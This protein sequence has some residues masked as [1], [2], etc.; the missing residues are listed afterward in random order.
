MKNLLFL[1]PSLAFASCQPEGEKP[2]AAQPEPTAEAPAEPAIDVSKT[3]SLIG[4]PLA[5]VEA[6]CDAAEVMHRV[7][8]IDGE[9][10]ITT[11]D[12]RP[13]RLNFAI[14]KG[15]ITKVTKG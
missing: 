7:V 13:E 3:D 4:K 5:K 11:R 1:I 15:V 12:Y 10:Q 2:A 8:E 14:V 9:P 6:A